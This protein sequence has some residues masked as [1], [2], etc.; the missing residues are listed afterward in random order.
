LKEL[1]AQ[2]PDRKNISARV[3]AI[4]NFQ[5]EIVI[6]HPFLDG[7]GR[8][9]RLVTDYLFR[10]LGLPPPLSPNERDIMSSV[11]EAR[12]FALGQMRA[13]LLAYR[14]SLLNQL[15]E[16][17]NV[18]TLPKPT[19]TSSSSKP[20]NAAMQA[21]RAG[22]RK[23]HEQFPTN[24]TVTTVV[25]ASQNG[26]LVFTV[27][28]GKLA[29]PERYMLGGESAFDTAFAALS[30][31]ETGVGFSAEQVDQNVRFEEGLGF[32]SKPSR[33]SAVYRY[34]VVAFAEI[35]QGSEL[36]ATLQARSREEINLEDVLPEHRE[37]VRKILE[38]EDMSKRTP[39]ES[40]VNVKDYHKRTAVE[41]PV[42]SRKAARTQAVH[43][44]IKAG[45]QVQPV[46]AADTVVEYYD[47]NGNFQGIVLI[48]RAADGHLATPGGF[49]RQGEPRSKSRSA[50]ACRYSSGSR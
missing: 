48:E 14:D 40:L 42:D 12:E 4:L 45:D 41:R 1:D 36:P 50:F 16:E 18:D 19:H 37:I 26:K 34:S 27:R 29:L 5:K 39:A 24:P 9:S 46:V 47:E 44:K 23:G 10:V 22:T 31:S 20:D 32:E 25:A 28:D 11:L 38:G 3:D 21:R 17:K 33:S 43:S 7:N 2:D 6:I 13:Y 30:D 15:D 8:S 35:N 49:A